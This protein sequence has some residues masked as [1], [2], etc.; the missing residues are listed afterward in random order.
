MLHALTRHK[1]PTIVTW[2][3]LDKSSNLTLSGGN[4]I[5]K[6]T[7]GDHSHDGSVRATTGKSS[8]KWYWEVEQTSNGAGD[9]AEVGVMN[10]SAPLTNYVGSSSGGY[11]YFDVNGKKYNSG[12]GTTF[13]PPYTTFNFIMVALDM[14]AGKVWFG[15]NGNWQGGSLPNPATG[16]SPAF[17][18]LSG[19]M[20][21]AVGMY[22]IN[23]I[24]TA[25]FLASSWSYVAPSGFVQL[26]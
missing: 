26:T 13:G 15:L 2:N 5:A 10:L 1:V 9:S 3:P 16:T 22:D 11:A 18:G 7:S 19:T 17:S 12:V 20:Y 8:G 14:D 23:S 4:L 6:K 21:P 24:F 25:K